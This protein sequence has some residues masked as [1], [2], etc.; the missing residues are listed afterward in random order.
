MLK[1]Q[2]WSDVGTQKP[3]GGDGFHLFSIYEERG[4]V[5]SVQSMISP[6][7]CTNVN[8]AVVGRNVECQHRFLATGLVS[9]VQ[10]NTNKVARC[11]AW[12]L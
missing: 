7:T 9:V 3:E 2:E 6:M 10:L 1:V 12:N 11:L 5:L 8:E 4:V